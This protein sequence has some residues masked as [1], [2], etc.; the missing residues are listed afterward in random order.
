MDS[1]KAGDGYGPL[2]FRRKQLANLVAFCDRWTMTPSEVY[3]LTAEEYGAF[4]DHMAAEARE[5]R[6][7]EARAR[8]RRMGRR[9]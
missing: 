2:P 4:V 5:H 6:K 1:A 7:A 3:A 9:R 8:N